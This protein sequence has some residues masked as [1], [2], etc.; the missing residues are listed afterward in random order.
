MFWIKAY[1]NGYIYVDVPYEKL[2]AEWPKEY[3]E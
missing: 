1:K 3:D 2:G